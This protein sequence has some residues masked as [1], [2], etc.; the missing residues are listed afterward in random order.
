MPGGLVFLRGLP[1]APYKCYDCAGEAESGNL[2][3]SNLICRARFACTAAGSLL[4]YTGE[5]SRVTFP[6]LVVPASPLQ[7]L[8]GPLLYYFPS[9]ASLAR[10]MASA[11]SATCSLEKILEM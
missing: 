1:A 4:R 8:R 7:M 5:A 6:G 2:A 10:M 9:P 3:E 11:R